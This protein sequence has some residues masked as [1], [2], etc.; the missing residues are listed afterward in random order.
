MQR[1][2]EQ[3]GRRKNEPPNLMHLT[4]C[5][6]KI[7]SCESQLGKPKLA[8]ELLPKDKWSSPQIDYLLFNTSSLKTF[9]HYLTLSSI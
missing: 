3:C 9:L 6:A 2:S 7:Y 1:K 5:M 4:I 8:T